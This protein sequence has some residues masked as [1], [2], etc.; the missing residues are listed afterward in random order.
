MRMAVSLDISPERPMSTQ[1]IDLAT[2]A[3]LVRARLAARALAK[4]IGLGVMD[5][6]RFAT[7]V[8]ELSRNALAVSYTHLTLPTKRIV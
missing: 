8:S 6:T 5:Q 1:T 4:D 7:A 2:S 3:D